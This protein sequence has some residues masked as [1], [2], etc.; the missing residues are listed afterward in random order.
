[1]VSRGI[2]KPGVRDR[3]RASAGTA[4][5]TTRTAARSRGWSGG[6]RHT[7]SL[8]PS[9]APLRRYWASTAKR[10][11]RAPADTRVAGTVA[12]RVG[13]AHGAPRRTAPTAEG[14]GPPPAARSACTAR[15][16]RSPGTREGRCSL[17]QGDSMPSYRKRARPY[18]GQNLLSGRRSGSASTSP[19]PCRGRRSAVCRHSRGTSGATRRCRSRGRSRSRSGRGPEARAPQR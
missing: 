4:M 12:G 5:P 16:H 7:R 15:A 19:R 3:T 13:D 17:R 14:P 10:P 9:A 18:G 6:S 8:A 11:G 2:R 1:M